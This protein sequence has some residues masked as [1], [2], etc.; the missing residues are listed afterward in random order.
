MSSRTGASAMAVRHGAAHRA[1]LPR[2]ERMALLR[3]GMDDIRTVVPCPWPGRTWSRPDGRLSDAVRVAGQ[4]A[5]L[6][7]K[8]APASRREENKE[9]GESH[10]EAAAA[11]DRHRARRPGLC[12]VEQC[13]AFDHAP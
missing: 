9:N 7:G 11:G 3:S 1:R 12:A 8:T 10:E 5:T 6:R 4:R 13:S 2:L